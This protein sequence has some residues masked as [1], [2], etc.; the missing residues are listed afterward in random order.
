MLIRG[1]PNLLA[2][3]AHLILLPQERHCLYYIDIRQILTSYI[4]AVEA[5]LFSLNNFLSIYTVDHRSDEDADTELSS[6]GVRGAQA[7][8]RSFG[9]DDILGHTSV[10][11][12]ARRGAGLGRSPLDALFTMTTNFDS[13][14]QKSG[15]KMQI[16]SDRQ[17]R[18]C[19]GSMAKSS[20]NPFLHTFLH[21]PD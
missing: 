13:L 6:G 10:T 1:L 16:P 12:V 11:S 7:G 3:C 9:I 18:K 5:P 8:V 20:V 15:A 17:A 14:K 4:F 2:N 19:L 21:V